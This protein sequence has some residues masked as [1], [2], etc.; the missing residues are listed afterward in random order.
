MHRCLVGVLLLGLTAWTVQ[1][2]AQ[3]DK[4]SEIKEVMAKLNKPSGIYFSLVG[5]MKEPQPDWDEARMQARLLAQLSGTLAKGTP[6]KGDKASWD[7]MVKAYIESAQAAE[8]AVKKKDKA[9]ALAALVKMGEPTCKKCH[10]A[11]RP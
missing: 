1:V 5:E 3:G 7:K 6:P 9:A 2:S 11:H 8:S 4:P 10:Q